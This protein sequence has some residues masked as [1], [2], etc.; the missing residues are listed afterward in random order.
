MQPNIT[1]EMTDMVREFMKVFDQSIYPTVQ[2]TPC[3][4]ALLRSNL[5]TEEA[6]EYSRAPW[7]SEEE[8]D[9]ICDLLYVVIGTNITMSVPVIPILAVTVPVSKKI[10]LWNNVLNITQDLD[11]RFPCANIQFKELNDLTKLLIAIATGTGY[12]LL[13]AFTAVHAKN[14]SKLWQHPPEGKDLIIVPKGT[15][16][17]VKRA[18]GKVVKPPTFTPPD[19]KAYL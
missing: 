6:K 11:C 2:Q 8:L 13:P 16:W 4:V 15:R 5:I 1:K 3:E 18:D 7:K 17:L 12:K 9:A 14:M 10:N 19:L